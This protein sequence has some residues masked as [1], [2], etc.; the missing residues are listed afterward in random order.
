MGEEGVECHVEEGRWVGVG[1][2]GWVQNGY[3]CEGKR[4]GRDRAHGVGR[5]NSTNQGLLSMAVNISNEH[6]WDVYC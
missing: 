1:I 2:E 4:D 6:D 3:G 5:G